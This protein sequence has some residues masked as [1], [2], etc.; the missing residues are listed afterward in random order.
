MR[1]HAVIGSHRKISNSQ[2]VYSYIAHYM[3]EHHR[4]AT[5][6]CLNM[7][8]CDLP[9]WSEEAWDNHSALS[10]QWSTYSEEFKAA[11]GLIFIVPEWAGVAPSALKNLFF[12]LNK[13]E[14]S[15][16]PALLIGVSSGTGGAYPLA[17][18]RISS[19]KN[20]GVVYI[21]DQVVLRQ[22]DGLLNSYGS[23]ESEADRIVQ[24]RMH[25]S[26]QMLMAYTKALKIMREETVFNY[27]DFPFGQ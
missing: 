4:N 14:M 11:D 2:K 13:R 3:A 16:K 27:K 22:V 12:Y 20:T 1:I 5:L 6:S 23:A 26:L 8:T 19:H 24:E 10:A 15:H 21:P 18:L 25:Y 7:S 17:E 9:F